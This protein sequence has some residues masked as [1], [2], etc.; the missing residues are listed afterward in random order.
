[1]RSAGYPVFKMVNCMF[2]VSDMEGDA[3]PAYEA[4]TWSK[5]RALG[6]LA[7]S[8][9]ASEHIDGNTQGH[10]PNENSIRSVFSTADRII[11]AG[12]EEPQEEQK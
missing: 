4:P 3:L 6:S 10:K 2:A 9:V 8:Q 5:E 11:K 1:M 7:I 12:R